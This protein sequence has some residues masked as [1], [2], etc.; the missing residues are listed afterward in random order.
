LELNNHDP[1]LFKPLDVL[2][3]EGIFID[4]L[5]TQFKCTL[6]PAKSHTIAKDKVKITDTAEPASL[7]IL[8]ENKSESKKSK[9]K[10]EGR[11]NMKKGKSDVAGTGAS[12]RRRPKCW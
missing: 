8:A 5:Q 11:R 9:A 2:F 3:S 6:Q 1:S 7:P 4:F 10:R 12:G